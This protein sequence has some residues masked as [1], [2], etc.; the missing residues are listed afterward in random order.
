MLVRTDPFRD[1]DRITQ[2]LL[3]TATRPAAMPM[4]A[5]RQGDTFYIHFD[6]PGVTAESVDLTV[7]QNV[8]TVRAERRPEQPDGA[9]M[10]VAERPAGVF[11]RQVFLGDTL[12]TEHIGADYS[13]GVLTLT[14]PVHEQAKP[15]SI[16]ITGHDEHKQVTA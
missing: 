7:E 13:A 12:D 11:T 6:L 2:Q 8:L 16:H 15:R 1:L 9:E 5:Y 4:D 10:I 3:G 14:I